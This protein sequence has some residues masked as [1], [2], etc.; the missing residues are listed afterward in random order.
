MMRDEDKKAINEYKIAKKLLTNDE[1]SAI[2]KLIF[3]NLKTIPKEDANKVL[4]E[5]KF[6]KKEI[7]YVNE[8]YANQYSYAS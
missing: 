5:Y 2:L 1:R 7:D 3:D 8:C 6:S 4:T